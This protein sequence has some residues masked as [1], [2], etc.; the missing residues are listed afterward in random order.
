MP[1][2]LIWHN[3][4]IEITQ[5]FVDGIQSTLVLK[6]KVVANTR[7]ANNKSVERRA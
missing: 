1:S 3:C 6:K 5:D 7:S 4:P 2:T